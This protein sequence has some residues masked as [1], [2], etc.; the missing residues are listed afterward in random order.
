MSIQITFNLITIAECARVL[1]YIYANECKRNFIHRI[2][3]E[4]TIEI[5]EHTNA[6]CVNGTNEIRKQSKK[7]ILFG[8]LENQWSFYVIAVEFCFYQLAFD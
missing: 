8:K 1:L 6:D 2:E 5:A 3:N 7:K 4:V